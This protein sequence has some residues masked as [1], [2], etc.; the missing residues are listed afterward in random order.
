MQTL[1][2]F[3]RW[4]HIF[5][6][7][8]AVGSAFFMR[9]VLLPSIASLRDE[10][11]AVISKNITGRARI[12]I[13]TAIMGILISGLYNLHKVWSKT[14]FPYGFIFMLKLVLAMIVF[15]VA[16]LLTSSSPQR[17]TFQSNRKTWLTLNVGLAV[18]IVALSAFLRSLH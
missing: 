16:I 1:D 5:S 11:K 17:A 14:V 3:M 15:T 4:L 2:L 7:I 8:T 13:H 6:V 10:D 18:I 12:W 9:F